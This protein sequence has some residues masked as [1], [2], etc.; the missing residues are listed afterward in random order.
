[1]FVVLRCRDAGGHR[2]A[3]SALDHLGQGV[4]VKVFAHMVSDVGPDREQYALPLVITR[5]VLVGIAE[6]ARL[7]RTIN[8]ADDLRQRDEFGLSGQNV[9][10]A[11]APFRSYESCPF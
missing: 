6:V 9:A 11:D 4:A 3:S 8:G 5:S 10:T 7:N 1:M 2:V